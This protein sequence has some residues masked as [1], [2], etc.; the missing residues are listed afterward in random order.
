MVTKEILVSE[1]RKSLSSNSEVKLRPK[2]LQNSVFCT[3]VY[4]DVIVFF[5]I[6]AHS[7]LPQTYIY[8]R[9]AKKQYVWLCFFEISSVFLLKR[10]MTLNKKYYFNSHGRLKLERQEVEE[11]RKSEFCFEF[12]KNSSDKLLVLKNE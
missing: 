7:T 3:L 4:C 1:S 11:L 2:A 8:E 9:T 5:L 6:R 10:A 12:H